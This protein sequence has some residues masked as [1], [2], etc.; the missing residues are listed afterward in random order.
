MCMSLVTKL[1]MGVDV[2]MFLF[3]ILEEGVLFWGPQ[4][5]K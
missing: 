4:S 5:N 3:W 1:D 2:S